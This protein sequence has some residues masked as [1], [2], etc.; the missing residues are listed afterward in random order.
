MSYDETENRIGEV[1]IR[2]FHA[3]ENFTKGKLPYFVMSSF[4]H[5][6]SVE[7]KQVWKLP[8]NA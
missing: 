6:L 7:D 5:Q 3:T 4:Q 1:L 2:Q 8:K